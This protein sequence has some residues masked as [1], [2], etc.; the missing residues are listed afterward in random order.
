[1][2]ESNRGHLE[3]RMSVGGVLTLYLL[4][5]LSWSYSYK[6][7]ARSVCS[8]DRPCLPLSQC[9]EMGMIIDQIQTNKTVRNYIRENTCGFQGDETKV[10]CSTTTGTE[11]VEQPN[12]IEK[13]TTTTTTTTSRP[14]TMTC[15]TR[16]NFNT[17]I[18]GGEE[19]VPGE[20]PWVALL[21][22]RDDNM[23]CGGVLISARHVL[24]AAHCVTEELVEVVLGE[25]DLNTTH[26]CL[27][28][29]YG[30][31]EKGA[32]CGSMCAPASVVVKVNQKI[33]HPNY[34]VDRGVAEF[35]VA[36]LELGERVTFTPYIQP[37][38]LPSPQEPFMTC[39]C[40]KRYFQC[41][42]S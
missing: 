32:K 41:S 30:C 10:C 9:E 12:S 13:V 3:P 27:D 25:H 23:R 2:G 24:T 4:H 7:A 40:A 26:D 28:P 20:W 16:E 29:D 22:Y 31:N 38:C 6:V 33:V 35:D 1:M 42:I 21:R 5:G 8:E 11:T 18:V 39:K 14:E 15:G 36:I 34:C 19:T 17:L 37:V